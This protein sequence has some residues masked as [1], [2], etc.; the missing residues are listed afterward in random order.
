MDKVESISLVLIYPNAKEL[1]LRR[2]I[3]RLISESPQRS[4]DYLE[5][6]IIDNLDSAS[7]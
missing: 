1:S 6:V 5:R 2:V 7:K 3:E 4:A